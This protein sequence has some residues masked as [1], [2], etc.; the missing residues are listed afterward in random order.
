MFPLRL[1]GLVIFGYNRA[2]IL[3]LVYLFIFIKNQDV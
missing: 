1:Y 3:N 2:F